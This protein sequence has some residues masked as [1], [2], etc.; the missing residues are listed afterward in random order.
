M[1]LSSAN[2]PSSYRLKQTGN[3]AGC[4][5]SRVGL[6]CHKHSQEF[7][8]WAHLDAC[9]NML[10]QSVTQTPGKLLSH[11]WDD[12]LSFADHTLRL[13][14]PP[15]LALWGDFF[16]LNCDLEFQCQQ[17]IRTWMWQIYLC[18]IFKNMLRDIT[19]LSLIRWPDTTEH[20]WILTPHLWLRHRTCNGT[21]YKGILFPGKKS[22]ILDDYLKL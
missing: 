12:N 8:A 6:G 22:D 1:A 5:K 4:W 20:S 15:P 21:F 14:L 19:D 7:G 13:S 3:I 16:L 2:R 10:T 9:T 18:W 11:Q 17:T